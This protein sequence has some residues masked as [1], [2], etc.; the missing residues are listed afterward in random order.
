MELARE[1]PAPRECAAWVAAE[2]A[3]IAR[4]ETIEQLAKRCRETQGVRE[5]ADATCE[6][7]R[8]AGGAPYIAA[9]RAREVAARAELEA[10]QALAAT[11]D[12][13]DDGA[14]SQQRAI[15]KAFSDTAALLAKRHRTH[16]DR[17]ASAVATVLAEAREV[18]A[19]EALALAY[20]DPYATTPHG[21]RVTGLTGYLSSG[22]VLRS[23]LDQDT[24]AA[25]ERWLRT[26]VL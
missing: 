14:A 21:E 23:G 9:L 6:R 18:A 25:L 10:Q 12:A 22:T 3:A 24:I 8:A 4:A 15:R 5:A 17:L 20:F 11:P 13:E 26:E 1:I 7:L 16:A 2:R 19:C